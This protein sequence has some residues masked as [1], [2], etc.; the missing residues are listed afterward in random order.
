MHVYIRAPCIHVCN[1]RKEPQPAPKADASDS[2]GNVERWIGRWCDQVLR[3]EEVLRNQWKPTIQN[4]NMKLRVISFF[5]SRYRAFE[6]YIFDN[7]IDR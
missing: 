3:V 2:P 5:F 7:L 1:S 4:D 6:N